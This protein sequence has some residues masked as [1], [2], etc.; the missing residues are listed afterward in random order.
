MGSVSLKGDDHA[1]ASADLPD[2]MLNVDHWSHEITLLF[3]H[4]LRAD[5]DNWSEPAMTLTPTEA[6]QKAESFI[7]DARIYINSKMGNFL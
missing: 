3:E 2:D 1:R 5:Y 7:E 4:R 6:I